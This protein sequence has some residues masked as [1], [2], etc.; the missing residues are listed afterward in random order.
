MEIFET[1]HFWK[2]YAIRNQKSDVGI[3]YDTFMSAI[4]DYKWP[5]YTAPV[6]GKSRVRPLR[7]PKPLN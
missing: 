5:P 1:V 4:L 7:D 6:I 3:F 2:R